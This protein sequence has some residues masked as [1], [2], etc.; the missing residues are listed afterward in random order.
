MQLELLVPRRWAHPQKDRL[1]AWYTR[2]GYEVVRTASFE[3]VAAP[4]APKLATP[5]QFLV[6]RKSLA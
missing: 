2:L 3:Q 5:C 1:H 6:F 4:L